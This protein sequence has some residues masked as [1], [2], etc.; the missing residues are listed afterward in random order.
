MHM[1]LRAASILA[2]AFCVA[3]LG[4]GDNPNAGRQHVSGKVTFK[5]AAVPFG[6]IEFNPEPKANPG[7]AQASANIQSGAYDTRN[8]RGTLGGAVI[9][10]IEGFDAEGGRPIFVHEEKMDLPKESTTRDFDVPADAAKKAP[11]LSKE[12]V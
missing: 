1:Y 11:E 5:G 7:G 8:G 6:R 10:R 2:L 12:P 3:M 4:C 9:V